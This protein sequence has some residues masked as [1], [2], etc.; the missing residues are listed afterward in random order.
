M[1]DRK[2]EIAQTLPQ[3]RPWETILENIGLSCFGFIYSEQDNI[4]IFGPARGLGW[5]KKPLVSWPPMKKIQ[6]S[7]INFSVFANPMIPPLPFAVVRM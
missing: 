2:I 4:L 1:Q 3:Q 7:W 6:R 5:A